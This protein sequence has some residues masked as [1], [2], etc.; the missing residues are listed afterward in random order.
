[1]QIKVINKNLDD[2]ERIFKV[3][4]MNYNEIHS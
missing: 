4:R 3:R 1:M 2:F